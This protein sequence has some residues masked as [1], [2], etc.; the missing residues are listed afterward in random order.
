LRVEQGIAICEGAKGTGVE[1]NE[2][3]VALFGA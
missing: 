1:W 3:A 2:N